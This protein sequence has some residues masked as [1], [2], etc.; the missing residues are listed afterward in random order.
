LGVEVLPELFGDWAVILA[1]AGIILAISCSIKGVYPLFFNYGTFAYLT[2]GSANIILDQRLQ[3]VYLLNLA[4][5]AVLFWI[6]PWLVLKMRSQV[7]E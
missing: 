5:G 2:V 6:I 1:V 7:N 3:W 4:F